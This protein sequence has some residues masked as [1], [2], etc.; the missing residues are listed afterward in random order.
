MLRPS[1]ENEKARL[2][3]QSE[4]R[5]A[6]WRQ[7]AISS[8]LRL[9]PCTLLSSCIPQRSRVIHFLAQQKLNFRRIFALQLTA[10]KPKK[11]RLNAQRA[12]RPS[13]ISLREFLPDEYN[14]FWGGWDGQR[15]SMRTYSI[16]TFAFVSV[17]RLIYKTA[18]QQIQLRAR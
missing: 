9:L 11:P 16:S 14:N 5:F 18:T 3:I 12:K 6:E 8:S 17:G 13:L 1:T 7:T 4:R 15:S 10:G 2:L